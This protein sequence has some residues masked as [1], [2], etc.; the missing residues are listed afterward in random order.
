MR[1]AIVHDWLYVAGGAERVLKELLRCYPGADVFTLFD[2]LTDEDRAWIGFEKSTTSFLQR[3][4]GIAKIHRALL[5]ILPFAIE[6][7]DLSGYDLVISS[8]YAV[9][10]GVITGPDQLHIAYIH[11]PMRYAWDLQHQYLRDAP[12]PFGLKAAFARIMLHRIRTWD[13]SSGIRP[14][15]IVANSAYVGRRV[16]KAFGRTVSVIHPPVDVTPYAAG[17]P[18]EDYFLAAGRLVS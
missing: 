5:P 10:K 11:S 12:G 6:Q 3:I 7:F 13:T 1:V 4:P 9:A 14:D 18:R 2:V 16:R 8:S 17:T 15:V